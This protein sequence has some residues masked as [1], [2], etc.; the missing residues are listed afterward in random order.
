MNYVLVNI[1]SLI[2]W[3]LTANNCWLDST[4]SHLQQLLQFLGPQQSWPQPNY[5]ESTQVTSATGSDKLWTSTE[6]F[7]SSDSELRYNNKWEISEWIEY[8]RDSLLLLIS[9][10]FTQRQQQRHH[11]CN[12]ICH[13][14]LTH[15]AHRQHTTDCHSPVKLLHLITY[16]HTHYWQ[17]YC[18]VSI[19]HQL[20]EPYFYVAFYII[21]FHHLLYA[22]I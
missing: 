8:T 1:W 10:F 2:L 3:S 14:T 6:C 5:S 18:Y 15:T 22:S 12:C 19:L 4:P 16:H 13:L 9:L 11:L 20:L 21:R 7:Q 17:H